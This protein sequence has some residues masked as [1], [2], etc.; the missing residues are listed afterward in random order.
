ML[1]EKI[2]SN[3]QKKSYTI[4]QSCPQ[5]CLTAQWTNRTI[6]TIIAPHLNFIWQEPRRCLLSSSG[7]GAY[8]DAYL[9]GW[10]EAVVQFGARFWHLEKHW[11]KSLQAAATA[12]GG[13]TPSVSEQ[14]P[15]LWTRLRLLPAALQP[16]SLSSQLDPYWSA[17]KD[18]L[19]GHI[20]LCAGAVRDTKRGMERAITSFY[21]SFVNQWCCL[22]FIMNWGLRARSRDSVSIIHSR[23]CGVCACYV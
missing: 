1:K 18:G 12:V 10:A 21:V 4:I 7:Q 17:Q 16:Q 8:C 23:F 3:H 5:I 20:T 11:S 22:L 9:H 15:C 2:C 13:D 14:A 6:A 19:P